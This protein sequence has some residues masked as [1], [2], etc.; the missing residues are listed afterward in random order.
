VG[1]GLPVISTLQ[2]MV[3]SGDEIV[4]IEGILSGT[5]SFLF[6]SFSPPESSGSPPKFSQIV[7]DAKDKGFTVLS[8]ALALR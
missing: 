7:L 8:L 3:E 6:N 1:A 5:L 2:D 4:K